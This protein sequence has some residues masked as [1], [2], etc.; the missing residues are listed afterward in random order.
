[1]DQLIN[2][3]NDLWIA[4][5][6]T[7]ITTLRW[8]ALYMIHNPDIQAKVHAE[9]DSC[10]DGEDRDILMSDKNALPYTMAVINVSH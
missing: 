8:G 2:V 7:T 1:M 4:G 3:L 9:I 10:I 6:E 5:M